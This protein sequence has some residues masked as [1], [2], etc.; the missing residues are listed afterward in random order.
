MAQEF[1]QMMGMGTVT[2]FGRD[3]RKPEPPRRPFMLTTQRI[4]GRFVKVAFSS[5]SDALMQVAMLVQADPQMPWEI[6]NTD[7]GEVVARAI[8]PFV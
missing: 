5:Y 7:A 2:T 8:F 4:G 1:P 6:E 3:R